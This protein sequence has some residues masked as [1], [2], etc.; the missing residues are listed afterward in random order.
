MAYAF[1]ELSIGCKLLEPFLLL[2][3]ELPNE[4]LDGV[5]VA[6]LLLSMPAL[7]LP[8]TTLALVLHPLNRLVRLNY[9]VRDCPLKLI[10]PSCVVNV[11][12]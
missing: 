10:V 12:L 11:V 3:I 4:A 5:L 8:D 6:V 1:L 9:V 7:L 2:L